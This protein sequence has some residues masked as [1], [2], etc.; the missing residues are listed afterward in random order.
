MKNFFQNILVKSHNIGQGLKV[1]CIAV[2][3]ISVSLSLFSQETKEIISVTELIN[4]LNANQEVIE[5]SNVEI[6]FFE[7]DNA[8][9][10][11]KIFYK[12]FTFKPKYSG[13]QKVYFYDCDFNTGP[14][15]PLVFSGW[16]F[17]KMNMVGCSFNSSV[18]IE[19][20]SQSGQYPLL[21]E[22]NSFKENIEFSGNLALDNIEIRNCIFS[23]EFQINTN[24]KELIIENNVKTLSIID[25]RFIAD[26]MNLESDINDKAYFQLILNDQSFEQLSILNCQFDN[27]GIKNIFSIDFEDC[28]INKLIMFDNEMNTL[29]FTGTNIENSLLIDSLSVT[30][31]IAVQ[32]FDFPESNTNIPWYNFGGE[33]LALLETTESEQLILYQAKTREQILNTL[34]FNDLMSVYNKLNSMYHNRGDIGSANESYVEIKTIETRRQKYLLEKTWNLNVYIN[35]KLNVFL[36]F[37][38]DYATNPGK[39]LIISLWVLLGFTLLYML[40][41]SEWDGMNYGYFLNQF[42]LFAQ[43]IEKDKTTDEIYFQTENP[44]QEIMQKLKRKYL[45]AGKKIPKMLRFFGRPL[46]Y[47]GK[48]RYEMMPK[49]I[50]LFNFQS[51]SWESLSLGEKFYSGVLI[52]III[53]SFLLY[54]L[55]IKLINAFILSLNSFVVVGFGSLPEK[56][57][58]MYLSIIEGVIGWFLLTFFTIT[59]LSQVLQSA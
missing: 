48:F 18:L 11:N 25:S 36:S 52:A 47:L 8:L 34:Q 2:A 23:K 38:S 6:N 12:V 31:F 46:H 10:E 28:D 59:L 50:R 58:A 5:V 7:E 33:K 35:Y 29:N 44:H 51:K 32:N 9:A 42:R 1:I 49:L 27:N 37:F 57:F 55:I 4:L 13:A 26:T 53:S 41:F 16:K 30:D 17:K 39:S 56:G 15:V 20:C 24:V 14:K 45:D 3:F 40:S 22:N 19:N 43:Y 54:V 21:F